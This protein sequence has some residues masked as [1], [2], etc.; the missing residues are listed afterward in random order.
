M[1]GKAARAGN[2]P[3]L[4]LLLDADPA[5]LNDVNRNGD[6]PLHAAVLR[7]AYATVEYLLGQGANVRAR[8]GRFS[9]TPLHTCAR[10]HA[11]TPTPVIAFRGRSGVNGV[12]AVE[13]II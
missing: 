4:K 10:N 1:A 3:A 13:R 9:W 12:S 2:L 5:Q 11:S 6:T 8:A 7:N